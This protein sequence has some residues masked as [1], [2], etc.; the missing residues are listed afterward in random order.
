MYYNTNVLLLRMILILTFIENDSQLQVC[1]L[2]M[3]LILTL[4]QM[5][6]ILIIR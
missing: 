3:I 6:M 5:R 1:F 4:L 2:R